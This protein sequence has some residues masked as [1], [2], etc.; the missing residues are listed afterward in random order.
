VY[1]F[2]LTNLT[3]VLIVSWSQR[4]TLRRAIQLA[5]VSRVLACLCWCTGSLGGQKPRLA[6][7]QQRARFYRAQ[8]QL[9][10]MGKSGSPTVGVSNPVKVSPSS[11]SLFLISPAG[12]QQQQQ[13]APNFHCAGGPSYSSSSSQAMQ[14]Q[15]L[16][17][18][19]TGQQHI[20]D[21]ATA[22]NEQQNGASNLFQ[23]M[24]QQQRPLQMHH[25]FGPQHNFTLN[26]SLSSLHHLHHQQ[27]H[28]AHNL[29]Q[30]QLMTLKPQVESERHSHCGQQ[31]Q[32]GQFLV[33]DANNA[34]RQ[35]QQQQQSLCHQAKA[36]RQAQSGEAD[37]PLVAFSSRPTSGSQ[38]QA[39]FGPNQ[40]TSR[41]VASASQAQQPQLSSGKRGE[42]AR[43][44]S[45]AAN[46]ISG[47]PARSLG[48]VAASGADANQHQYHSIGAGDAGGACGAKESA[49]AGRQSQPNY[50]DALRAAM[51]QQQQQQR[52]NESPVVAAHHFRRAGSKQGHSFGLQ[53]HQPGG[54]ID[55]QQGG[56]FG[57]DLEQQQR[58]REEEEEGGPN[59]GDNIY[60]VASYALNY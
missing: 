43:A 22:I 21:S 6:P 9:E 44:S 8:N 13:Y 3:L 1:V 16:Y 5:G 4:R 31:D 57:R 2:A 14:A 17:Q 28:Q 39:T 24:Q 26:R 36:G 52:E 46:C 49:A 40:T 59:L 27:H 32:A 19:L 41:L 29:D 20:Y 34:I 47:G 38:A 30:R 51:I 37:G 12:G 54:L 7:H 55:R 18:Q 45:A 15:H 58:R 35:Q 10:P 25:Q 56:C 60:D 42:E 33:L 53:R 48:G 11:Q 50:A 23:V